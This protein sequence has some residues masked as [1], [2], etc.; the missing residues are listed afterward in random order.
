MR[1][2]KP[3][4]FNRKVAFGDIKTVTNPNTGGK[5]KKFKAGFTVWFAPKNRT[6]DQKYEL[7]GTEFEDTKVII[8]RHKSAVADKQ[9][10]LI[11]SVQYD[12]IDYSPDETSALLGF[13]YVTLRRRS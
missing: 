7:V 3:S 10:A 5:S 9:M 4:E 8:V 6:L 2:I 11:D 1:K 13:D 12:I